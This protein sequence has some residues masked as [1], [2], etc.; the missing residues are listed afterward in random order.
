MLLSLLPNLIFILTDDLGYYSP[1]FVNPKMITPNIDY[2]ASQGM[3][4]TEHYTYMFCSP[5]RGALLTGR[6]PFKLSATRTNF[7]P[8]SV[9]DG[10]DLSFEY[11]P[12][13]LEQLNYKSHHIGKWYLIT[14]ICSKL[15]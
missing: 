15:R 5:S 10:I 13:K 1:G 12:Q 3:F 2:L 14:S 7:Q 8:L 11:L 9:E 6:Y 4:L